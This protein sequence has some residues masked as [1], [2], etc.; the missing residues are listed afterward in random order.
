MCFLCHANSYIGDNTTHVWRHAYNIKICV[1]VSK[2]ERALIV[3]RLKENSSSIHI[4]SHFW[5]VIILWISVLQFGW[6]VGWTHSSMSMVS[7]DAGAHDP[8][9]L[10]AFATFFN[11]YFQSYEWK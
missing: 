3:N 10:R 8:L 4:N 7:M 9:Y 1:A 2:C 6:D 11:S 5:C